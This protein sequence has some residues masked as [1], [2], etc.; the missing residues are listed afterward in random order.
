MLTNAKEVSAH[1]LKRAKT[2]KGYI[3]A[4]DAIMT[5]QWEHEKILATREGYL[6]LNIEQLLRD[7]Y[8]DQHESLLPSLS[9]P[10]H[11]TSCSRRC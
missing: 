3:P 1:I 9:R 11:S 4:V 10:I 8:Q 7:L 6:K 5:Q 2:T